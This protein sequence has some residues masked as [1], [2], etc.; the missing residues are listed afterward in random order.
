METTR[1]PA[2]TL[3][4]ARVWTGDP[5]QPHATSLTLRGGLVDSVGPSTSRSQEAADRSIDLG[6]RWVGTAFI[7]A[8]LHITLGAA[9]LA[10]CSLAGCT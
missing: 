3:R 9:T 1:P 6:G 7:D 2:I 10:Q 8:H 5:A 4:N